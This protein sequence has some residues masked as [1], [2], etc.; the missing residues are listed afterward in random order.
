MNC[1]QQ[2]ERFPWK[3]KL[4]DL[5]IYKLNISHHGIG[6]IYKVEEKTGFDN[7]HCFFPQSG[8]KVIT[9]YFQ[10]QVVNEER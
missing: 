7:L 8:R 10:L 4:G 2:T 5:V 9:H 3:A 1:D 6:Y